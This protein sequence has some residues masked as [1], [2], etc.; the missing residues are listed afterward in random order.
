MLKYINVICSQNASPEGFAVEV[1][2]TPVVVL[3]SAAARPMKSSSASPPSVNHPYLTPDNVPNY[4][5]K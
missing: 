3:T 5:I 2:E 1:I 4:H